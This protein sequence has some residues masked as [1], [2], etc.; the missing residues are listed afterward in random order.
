MIMAGWTYRSWLL[1]TT[2]YFPATALAK[3]SFSKETLKL[4]DEEN[5]ANRAE[6]EARQG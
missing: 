3:I 2:Y 5:R 6:L 4:I 1:G